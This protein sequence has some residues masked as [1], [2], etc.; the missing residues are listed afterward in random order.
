ML[1][2]ANGLRTNTLLMAATGGWLVARL[3]HG[4]PDQHQRLVRH[5]PL[6]WGFSTSQDFSGDIALIAAS[7]RPGPPPWCGADTPIRSASCAHG[8]GACAHREC[9]TRQPSIGAG[10]VTLL[11]G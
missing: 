4:G 11:T 7:S 3:Q 5:L 6:G 2:C 1:W 10:V 8:R 9:A